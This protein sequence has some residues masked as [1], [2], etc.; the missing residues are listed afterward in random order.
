MG[1]VWA[2]DNAAVEG[3][4]SLLQKNALNQKRWETRE[5][6]RLAIVVWTQ[7]TSHRQTRHRGL[8]KPTPIEFETIIRIT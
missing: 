8:G 5:E 1:R 7:E 2:S 3:R 4:F 6:L